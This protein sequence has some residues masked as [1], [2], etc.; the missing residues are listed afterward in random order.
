MHFN[1]AKMWPITNSTKDNI[2]TVELEYMKKCPRVTRRIILRA[3]EIWRIMKIV[4]I[5]TGQTKPEEKAS[6]SN[7]VVI[8][9][10][11]EVS[12]LYTGKDIYKI[13]CQK[14]NWKKETGE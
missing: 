7:R 4:F 3:E 11:K 13:Q 8:R 14:K 10:E 1:G 2:R 9:G 12:H 5:R 6:I